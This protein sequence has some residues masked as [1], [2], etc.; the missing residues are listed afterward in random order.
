MWIVTDGA[1]P[2]TERGVELEAR[3]LAAKLREAGYPAEVAK[4]HGKHEV[5]INFFA[6]RADAEASLKRLGGLSG[7]EAKVVAAR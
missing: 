4:N 6:T 7:N 2:G 5:R 1:L 3:E